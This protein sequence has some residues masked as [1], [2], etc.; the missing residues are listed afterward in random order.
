MSN[1][2]NELTDEDKLNIRNAVYDI[3]NNHIEQSINNGG[4]DIFCIYD[5]IIEYIWSL[6]N[7]NLN[8]MYK[9]FV[10]ET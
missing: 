6:R 2:F 1:L 8:E 5:K 7:E 9:K 3:L 4:C 10:K